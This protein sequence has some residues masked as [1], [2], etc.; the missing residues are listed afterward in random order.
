MS[1]QAAVSSANDFIQASSPKADNPDQNAASPQG[2]SNSDFKN[3]LMNMRGE[4][5]RGVN[6]QG[7]P[8]KNFAAGVV[9]MSELN[10]KNTMLL[11]ELAAA[12]ETSPDMKAGEREASRF[13]PDVILGNLDEVPKEAPEITEPGGGRVPPD[14]D[15]IPKPDRFED[16]SGGTA[17]SDA[18]ILE[19]LNTVVPDMNTAHQEDDG[20]ISAREG[21]T[22]KNNPEDDIVLPE[23][24]N[25]AH[26]GVKPAKTDEPEKNK[27]ADDSFRGV[28]E[29]KEDEVSA[30]DEKNKSAVGDAGR[31]GAK[32]N[33]DRKAGQPGS[34]KGADA[35]PGS[36]K[37]SVQRPAGEDVRQARHFNSEETANH[38][39]E[40]QPVAVNPF[41]HLTDAAYHA[42]QSA[43]V[44]MPVTYTLV[45]QDKFGEGLLSVVEFI[46]RG[47]SPQVRIIV[48]PPALGR[49]DVSLVSSANGVE[50]TFRV[51]SEELRQMVQNQIDA[52]KSS[53]QAQGIHVSGLT[54][55][56]RNGEGENSRGDRA[57][58]NRRRGVRGE[59]EADDPAEDTRIVRLDLE[60]GLLHWVA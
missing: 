3:V 19:T 35:G 49:V 28:L 4:P 37:T 40:Q 47:E 9:M 20:K 21:K 59:D 48:E 31:D 57:S 25:T 34:D 13:D 11:S 12:E 10:D 8:R 52:L 15:D 14:E 43:G 29:A 58:K 6:P 27:G 2:G 17:A 54:V 60:R 32:G 18:A 56:I 51:D 44:R 46:S 1:V 30:A 26:I 33:P 42:E 7:G 41:G 5:K 16:L 45:S 36:V 39:G 22:A 23:K 38:S 53:L 50:A 24:N 55:D